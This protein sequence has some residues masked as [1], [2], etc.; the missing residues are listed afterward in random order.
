MLVLL[1]IAASVLIM[2]HS[3]P[4][5]HEDSAGK[6]VFADLSNFEDAETEQRNIKELTGNLLNLLNNY[7][8]NKLSPEPRTQR[9]SS[10]K[11]EDDKTVQD[12]CTLLTFIDKF[13]K[14]FSSSDSAEKGEIKQLMRL[15]YRFLS[16]TIR[17]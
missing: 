12:I 17:D 6:Q 4:T 9:P 11:V 7:T 15:I 2:G 1:V 8:Q 3:L 14:K 5:E 13:S 10:R 16:S